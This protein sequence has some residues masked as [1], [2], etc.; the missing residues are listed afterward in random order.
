LCGLD[1]EQV[2]FGED[3][4]DWVGGAYLPQSRRLRICR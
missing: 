4:E 1:E 2:G 3:Y